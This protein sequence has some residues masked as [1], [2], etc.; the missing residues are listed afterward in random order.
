M[1]KF[2]VDAGRSIKRDGKHILSLTRIGDH[3]SII[4]TD[5]MVYKIV[6]LL[7][8]SDPQPMI[9]NAAV[10]ALINPDDPIVCPRC[11]STADSGSCLNEDIYSA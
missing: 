1:T 9:D 3:L 2:E 10:C 4:E 8:A 5:E 6:E 11:G 7:N